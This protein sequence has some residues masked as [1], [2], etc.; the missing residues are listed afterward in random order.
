MLT[1]YMEKCGAAQHPDFYAMRL[2]WLHLKALPDNIP[3]Q[4]VCSQWTDGI[5]QSYRCRYTFRWLL[6]L[7]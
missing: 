4:V 6:L 7:P 1:S 3:Q 2:L 5:F